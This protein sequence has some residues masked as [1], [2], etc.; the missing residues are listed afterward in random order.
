M[1]ELNFL[2]AG[3][4]GQGAILASNVLA[5]VGMMSGYDV[6]KSEVHGMS[7]R[8]GSVTSHVRWG[9]KV[10]SPLIEDGKV[11]YIVGLERLEPMRYLQ[12]LRL[13]GTI[14]LDPHAIIPI[15]VSS[16]GQTYPPEEVE[17]EILEKV[18]GS[19][20][21]VPGVEIAQNLG[22]AKAANVVILGALSGLL[23]VPEDIWLQAVKRMVPQKVLDLNLKAFARGRELTVG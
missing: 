14:V 12:A 15:T 21:W 17:R 19:V 20:F 22:N 16:C 10:R 7:Q 4:G 9:E 13:G 6:K 23:D 3:V 11:D 8:G 2:V 1:K 18:A 5:A